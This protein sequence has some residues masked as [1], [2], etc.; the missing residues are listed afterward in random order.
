MVIDGGN[1][2]FTNTERR[3]KELEADGLR[4]VGMGVSGGEEGARHGPSIM[5]GGDRGGYDALAPILDQIAAQVDDGP[6]VT[7]IGPG[8]RRPLRED[9]PQRHRVRRHAA[10][11]RGVRL[12]CAT[13]SA[14][15][16]ERAGRHLP[17]WNKGELQSFLIEITAK[18]FAHEGPETGKPLVDHI[19]DAAGRR[20]PASGPCRTPPSWRRRCRRSPRRSRRACIS[21]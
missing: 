16:T 9:G 4:F 7:Y 3:A 12:S 14:C 17:T 6:C 21:A 2:H 19:L 20:A 18:M 15:A 5:P 11:R 8:R 1:E 13:V 10:H